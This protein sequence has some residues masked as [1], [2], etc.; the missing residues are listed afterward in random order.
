MSEQRKKGTLSLKKK[1]VKEPDSLTTP[2]YRNKK[3]VIRSE[4]NS[5]YALPVGADK[6]IISHLKESGLEE[7]EAW[8][9]CKTML[10]NYTSNTLYLTY[11]TS[12]GAKRKNI[13]G[14][15]LE[16]KKGHAN[17]ARERLKKGRCWTSKETADYF[18]KRSSQ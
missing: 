18:L 9:K 14:N 6:I 7:L 16:V 8:K 4:R 17:K 5:K 12:E 11:L 3:K 15:F 2:Q 10:H 13:G 1:E